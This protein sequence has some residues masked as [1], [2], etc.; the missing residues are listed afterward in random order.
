MDQGQPLATNEITTITRRAIM[1][2]LRAPGVTWAGR[3]EEPEFLARLYDL[4]R[5]P[6]NDSR[7]EHAGADIVMHRIRWNDWADDWVFE[8]PRFALLNASDEMFLKFLCETVHP[9]V[10]PDAATARK[11]AAE[12][13]REL[14][15]DGYALVEIKQIS[16][17]PVFASERAGHEVKGA[18]PVESHRPE[19]ASAIVERAIADAE[20]LLKGGGAPSGLDRV[21]TALHGFLI[22]VCERSGIECTSDATVATLL[23]AIRNHHPAFQASTVRKQDITTILRTMGA[24][25]DALGTLRNNASAAHP[26][27]ELLDEPEAM[28]AINAARTILHYIDSRIRA[29]HQAH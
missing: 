1:D 3:L 18:T 26:N 21:H 22:A 10:R 29:D 20:T 27:K 17:R 2:I 28:L 15:N 7:C 25:A 14:A 13:N 12:Y 24:V 11:L 4:S 6:S 9:E 16:G 5:L 23:K 8:D 19:V